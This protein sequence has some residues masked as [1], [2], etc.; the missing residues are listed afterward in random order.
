[1]HRNQ[2]AEIKFALHK[3]LQLSN[4]LQLQQHKMNKIILQK[5]L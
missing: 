3:K 4:E 5:K 2:I 1:M